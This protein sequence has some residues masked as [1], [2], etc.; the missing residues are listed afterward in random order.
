[1]KFMSVAEMKKA[2]HEKIETLQSEESLKEVLNHIDI[3]ERKE[4]DAKKFFDKAKAQYG[5][6]LQKLAQ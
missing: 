4:F 6:V 3:V 2:I 1:M 5:D